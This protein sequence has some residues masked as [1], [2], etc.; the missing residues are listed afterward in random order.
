MSISKTRNLGQRW[1]VLFWVSFIIRLVFT[2]FWQK[3][4]PRTEWIRKT[5][6]L[7]WICKAAFCKA[8]QHLWCA[9][10]HM[11]MFPQTIG[12]PLYYCVYIF[13]LATVSEETQG[14]SAECTG[15]CDSSRLPLHLQAAQ[16]GL[17]R[18]VD[19]RATLCT[20]GCR[21]CDDLSEKR[22]KPPN[23]SYVTSAVAYIWC[24]F[25]SLPSMNICFTEETWPG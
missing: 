2:P 15:L 16:H 7:W 23:F 22:K 24:L 11:H 13:T 10:I 14:Q 19:S 6:L 4:V 18:F 25:S 20:R 17:L 1:L 5:F 12:L 3:L 9:C 8:K 21:S